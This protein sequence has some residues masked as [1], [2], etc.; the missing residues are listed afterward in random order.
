MFYRALLLSTI[1]LGAAVAQAKP[2]ALVE[3]Q[4]P[5]FVVDLRYNTPDNFLKKN[6]YADF[7]LSR[8]Y[9]HPDL[10]E[11]LNRLINQVL[12]LAKIESGNA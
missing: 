2:S 8:C 6:V 12:D 5:L 3:V 11:R 10:A 4:D 9:V 1:F 7:K